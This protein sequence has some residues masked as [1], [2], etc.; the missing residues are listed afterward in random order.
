MHLTGKLLPH[1][2]ELAG[3]GARPRRPDLGSFGLGGTD[4]PALFLL[5]VRRS[6]KMYKSH[7]PINNKAVFTSQNGK[8]GIHHH[9][10]A[11]MIGAGFLIEEAVTVLVVL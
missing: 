4:I 8:N 3:C 11:A 9:A 5:G 6:S 10:G 1:S 2:Q 7:D